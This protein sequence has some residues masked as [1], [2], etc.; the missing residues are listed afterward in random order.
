MKYRLAFRQKRWC[1][2]RQSIHMH[3]PACVAKIDLKKVEWTTI[4]RWRFRL[5]AKLHL[6]FLRETGR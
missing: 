2:Q 3:I 4:A 5:V 1:V 6:V